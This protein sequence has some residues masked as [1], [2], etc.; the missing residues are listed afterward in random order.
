MS[1]YV[2]GII[3]NIILLGLAVGYVLG[4]Y[5]A[6]RHHSWKLPYIVISLSALYLLVAF[7]LYTPLL[8]SFS[9][10]S[11]IIGSTLTLTLMFF[12]PMVFLAFIPPYLIRLIATR[13]AV[14]RTAG[15][16]YALSTLGSIAGGIMTTFVFIPY[17]GSRISF[18]I[19]IFLLFTI[20]TLGLIKFVSARI[21][22]LLLLVPVYFL[23]DLKTGNYLYR[24]E[25]EYNV[26][27]LSDNEGRLYLRLN[28]DFGHHSQ[29]L[30]PKTMLS[31]DYY[32]Y[33]LLPQML[34][35][36]KTTLILGNG[37]GTSMKQ[38]GHFFD[39][40]IDA[41]EIDSKLT[42]LGKIYFGLKLSDRMKIFHEDARTF[43]N[44]NNKKYDVIL[45]D[46]YGG[47][48]YVPFHVAT[49]QFFNLVR[50]ALTEN[51]V[52]AVNIPFFSLDQELGQY[53]LNTIE[54]VF[55]QTSFISGCV[56]YVFNSEMS[57][58]KLY[59]TLNNKNFSPEL[60][61]LAD[62]VVAHLKKISGTDLNRKL[63][64]NYAPIEKMTFEL[65]NKNISHHG[66]EQPS[67]FPQT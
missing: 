25:S 1:S 27:T 21:F 51:G 26:I 63:T 62:K 8:E 59:A 34:L 57:L 55:P 35:E 29:S 20:A 44:R 11:V 46:V 4:G 43:M 42:E 49:E 60:T 41:V 30:D 54:N 37:A 58:K 56:V 17:F 15:N 19:T 13:E 65:L 10:R 48:P 38:T 3:I 52:A 33:L 61:E 23:P 9:F 67:R 22:L 50:S 39:T 31:H 36:A 66:C 16:I 53:Y 12:I 24:G 28:D 64:D 47:G 18:L 6:D 45:V 32:D 2:T 40:E 5:V 14:G 7:L